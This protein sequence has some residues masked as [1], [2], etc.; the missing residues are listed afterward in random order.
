MSMIG[1]MWAWADATHTEEQEAGINISTV[2]TFTSM[3]ISTSY[4]SLWSRT[5]D[6]HQGWL[7]WSCGWQQTRLHTNN[8]ALLFSCKLQ[9][10]LYWSLTSNTLCLPMRNSGGSKSIAVPGTEYSFANSRRNQSSLA[11]AYWSD[12]LSFLDLTIKSDHGNGQTYATFP[13][14]RRGLLETKNPPV[15][16]FCPFS[17]VSQQQQLSIC[18]SPDTSFSCPIHW[19]NK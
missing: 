9:N 6:W 8:N 5:L 4:M 1:C 19:E 18:R 12:T 11:L 17:W 10:I 16:H 14:P 2:S 15:L 13:H 3:Q 7:I